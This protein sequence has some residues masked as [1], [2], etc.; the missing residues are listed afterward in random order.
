MKQKSEIKKD[1]S[2]I[3]LAAGNSSRMGFPKFAL[4]YSE[5]QTFI[6]HI[7]D[8]YEKFRC[9]EI[10]QVLNIDNYKFLKENKLQF[11]RKTKIVINDHPEWHRFY[12]LKKGVQALSKKVNIFV[13]NV[14]N[15]FVNHEVLMALKH[16]ADKYDYIYPEFNRRGGHPFLLSENVVSDL[17]N[18]LEN[19]IHLKKFLNQY[20]TKRIKVLDNK[21]LV[22]INTKTD[23]KKYFN[24]IE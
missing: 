11:P 5:S 13:H 2:V 8:E 9:T 18:C 1:F 23:Y 15:P 17:N 20:R 3:I 12:S 24:W 14:D 22:N 19:Q 7:A 21:V 6:E 16:N 4:K 10:V